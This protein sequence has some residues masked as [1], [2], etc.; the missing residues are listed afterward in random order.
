MQSVLLLHGALGCSAQLE[1]LKLALQQKGLVVFELNFSGHGGQPFSGN[2]GIE[3][4]ADE[5]RNY[6]ISNK[7]ESVSVFGYSMGGYVAVW[8]AYQH[9]ELISRVVTLGTKFDWS[10]ESAAREISKMNPERIE[11]KI[12]AFARLL[13]QRHAP[14]DWRELMQKTSTMMQQLGDTPLL[15]E[16]ILSEIETPITI[17]LGDA[18][19]MADR[20]YSQKVSTLLPNAK[21]HLLANTP[22]PIE[23]VNVDEMVRLIVQALSA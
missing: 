14:N 17:A 4:F 16:K 12:P 2:F 9:P 15:T 6:I 18:D 5:T 10:P 13:Q 23:K 21:F 19:D 8:L 11:Q 7:L 3:H 20:A 22:H 1:P